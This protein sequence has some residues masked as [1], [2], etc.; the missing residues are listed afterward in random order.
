MEIID[1]IFFGEESFKM[2]GLEHLLSILATGIIGFLIIYNGRRQSDANQKMTLK[3]MSIY[4]SVLIILWAITEQLLGKFNIENDLPLVFCNFIALL[5]PIYAFNRS[6]ILF[7]I[8]YYVI[9]GGAIQSII[10]PGLKMSFPHYEFIKFWSVH[11]GLIIFILY[12]IIVL[13]SRPVLKGVFWAFL[14]VQGHVVFS[15]FINMLLRSN[16]LFLNAKPHNASFLDLL[17]GWPYY[18]IWMDVILIPYFLLFY[19]P[20]LFRNRFRQIK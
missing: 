1:S 20:F 16:Y 10:T 3:I 14:F 17:G 6:K 8:L 18:I 5:L 7:N 11:S 15:Y 13:K 12:E 9:I 19:L 2:F 4:F